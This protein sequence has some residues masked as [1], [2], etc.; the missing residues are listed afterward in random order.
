MAVW[1][2]PVDT[3]I[4]HTFL[5][6][7]AR[8]ASTVHVTVYSKELESDV[9]TTAMTKALLCLKLLALFLHRT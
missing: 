7:P 8:S 6:A 2:V 3:T 1:G 5:S 4:L 9:T